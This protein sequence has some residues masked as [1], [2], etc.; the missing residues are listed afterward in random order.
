MKIKLD[1]LH[2]TVISVFGT[3]KS[4]TT[5]TAATAIIVLLLFK[6]ST[7]KLLKY[8]CFATKS[9][10]EIGLKKQAIFNKI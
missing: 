10:A 6:G 4:K 9:E 5:V 2:K 3:M 1:N 8:F 7:F